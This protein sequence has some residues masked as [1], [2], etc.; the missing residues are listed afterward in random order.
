VTTRS[1]NWRPSPDSAVGTHKLHQMPR[2]RVQLELEPPPSAS[3]AQY[4]P[5]ILDQG[6]QGSCTGHGSAEATWIS[7]CREARAH[8]LVDPPCPSP[9]WP[10]LLA[11]CIEG[12]ESEDSGAYVSDVFAGLQQYG[13]VS[14][15]ALPYSDSTLTPSLEQ[16]EQ[17]K[18]LAYDQRC[19]S[20]FSRITSTGTQ[21]QREI[22][23]AIAAGYAVV[24]GTVVDDAFEDIRPG[25]YWPGCKGQALGGH[26]MAIVGY[27]TTGVELVNSWGSSWCDRGHCKA[28]WSAVQEFEDLWIVSAVPSYS[29]TE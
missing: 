13:F 23:T 14:R 15:E 7:L 2:M 11:R 1:Y 10:Y 18:R 4:Q 3:V 28:A 24:F 20:G 6:D 8:G 26:C 17:L 16:F 9:A 29:G 25:Q 22:K 21:R 12:S 5:A 27:D 19:I